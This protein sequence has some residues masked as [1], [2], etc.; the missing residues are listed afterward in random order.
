MLLTDTDGLYTRNPRT[1]APSSSA[2]WT[3]ARC[4]PLDSTRLGQRARLGRHAHQ[5]G[6]SVDGAGGGVAADRFGRAAGDG[7]AGREARRWA[8]ASAR[9]AGRSRPGSYGCATASR[10]PGASSSTPERARRCSRAGRASAGRRGRVEGTFRAGDAVRVCTLE[11]E[12]FAT[13]VVAMGSAELRRAAG[14]HSA[15]AGV[16]E[17]IHRDNLVLHDGMTTESASARA[18]A[19]A[20]TLAGLGRG[21]EDAALEQIAL[22]LER[23]TRRDRRGQRR[24]SRRGRAAA[25]GA[26]L[27]RLTLDAGRVLELCDAVRA[28]AALDDP[29]GE[30]SPAGGCPTGSTSRRCACRSACC[31]SS[32]RRART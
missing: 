2:R 23:E 12:V 27:D 25:V 21:A 6:R 5:G 1:P 32:T 8:R 9:R 26:L 28:V 16:P 4:S 20:R 14:Q 7:L 17:A 30:S 3:T 22:A 31:S 24:G 19:A 13:G 18:R 10:R 29:V 15:V 11:G